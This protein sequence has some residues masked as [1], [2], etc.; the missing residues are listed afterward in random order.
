MYLY[1]YLESRTLTVTMRHDYHKPYAN[2]ELDASILEFIRSRATESTA[3]RI[4]RALMASGLPGTASVSQSQVYYQW[5]QANVSNWRR[6]ADQFLSAK[7]LLS[8]QLATQQC[9][10]S[11]FTSGNLR[12]LALFVR[13]SISSLRHEAKELAMDATFGTNNAGMDLFAVLAEV[14]GTG[15]VLAYLFVGMT[16]SDGDKRRT[17]PGALTSLLEQFLRRIQMAGFDPV[18]FGTDKDASE[19]A[20]VKLVW[21]ETTLQL[22]F[23]HA[24][25]ALRTKLKDSSTHKTQAGYFPGEAAEVIPGLEVCWGSI[26]TRRPNGD[27]RY[28]RCQC[29]SRRE[30]FEE[31]GRIEQM[32]TTEKDTVSRMF[33]R[34]FNA[35][36]LI[37]DRNGIFRSRTEIH[38]ECASEMYSWCK[39]L[40]FFRL[41]AY[42]FVNW[43]RPSQW[44]LW[45]RSANATHIPI[46]KTTMIVESHWRR[47]KHDFLH[48]FNRP[49][50]DLVSWVLVT[51]AIPAA[52][53][54]MRAVRSGND[55][56]GKAAW[57][58]DMK[59]EWKR[60][61]GKSVN[62]ESIQKHHTDPEQGVCACEAFLD[63]RFFICKHL[64]NSFSSLT[65]RTAF[66]STVQRRRTR[67]FLIHDQLVV[68][69]EFR[70]QRSIDK[71]AGRD[72]EGSMT[73]PSDDAD[74]VSNFEE[75]TLPGASNEPVGDVSG[76]EVDESPN[77]ED[78]VDTMQSVIEMVR[79]QHQQ[80]NTAFVDR[81]ISS[82]QGSRIL[83]EEVN[84]KKN[85]RSMTPTWG[86]YRHAATM[87]YK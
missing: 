25:R 26:P 21:P 37:P 69:P 87:Y 79:H 11:V 31:R 84:R 54:K 3:S 19:I 60:L 59:R 38:R 53:A 27:H 6:D 65:N 85:R 63:S 12:G 71:S 24:L 18:F 49:R 55:R 32:S 29:L 45:A 72:D 10:H 15:V 13:E 80:G 22:C 86:K 1:V 82:H 7:M 2:I 39:A 76:S 61:E 5:L 47:L 17:D 67:P 34:H 73:D 46:L 4:H 35:H 70:V 33:S 56:L 74:D 28:G 51:R 9:D 57:R 66:F 30:Q 52:V 16:P 83:V 20:A 40:G 8:E 42:L 68:L 62:P 77:V 64:V 75:E 41:W 43:Y 78:F 14:D 50:I 48:D 23:W 36:S 58:K 81:V 44:E